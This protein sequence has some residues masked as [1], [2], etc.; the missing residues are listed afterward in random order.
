MKRLVAFMVLTTFTQA[1][2]FSTYSF[3]PLFIVDHF[4]VDKQT[5]AALTALVAGAGFWASPLGG[6]LADR[7]GGIPVM[8]GLC[9]V[10]G[11][12]IYLLNFVP[13]GFMFI[14]F[15]LVFGTII[16][17]RMPVSETFIVGNTPAHLRSTMLGIYY[18]S[19][20]EGGGLLTPA[21][22][23]LIDRFGFASCFAMIGAALLVMT[24][25]CSLF[26]FDRRK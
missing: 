21:L 6:Y 9:I 8:L 20:M 24:A 26:L 14:A 13:Y 3:I 5:A 19:G 1:V 23:Y 12:L 22:G 16:I 10:S 2:V 18:F 17:M 7:F 25:I 11:P 4:R 15:L